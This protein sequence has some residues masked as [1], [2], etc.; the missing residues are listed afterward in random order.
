MRVF[1][2]PPLGKE[3]PWLGQTECGLA[4]P[5]GLTNE[6]E[7]MSFRNRAEHRSGNDGCSLRGTIAE[8]NVMTQSA[9]LAAV[10]ST[11]HEDHY[12]NLASH[13][14]LDRAFS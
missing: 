13:S 4:Q 12:A 3:V 7:S 9:G 1:V 5:L 6:V 8:E 2:E 10:L 11:K 14:Q